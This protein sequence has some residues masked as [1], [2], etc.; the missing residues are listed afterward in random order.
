MSP[1]KS[2]LLA[3]AA[4][5]SL[6]ACATDGYAS[7]SRTSRGLKGAAIGGAA[8]AGL[9]AV[10]GGD[11]LTGAAIGAAAGAVLGVVTSDRNRYEDREGYR[12]YYERDGRAY[13]YDRD[14]R[15]RYIGY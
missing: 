1:I 7:D 10:T 8:G 11:V 14:G 15:K 5:T 6:S 2:S 3:L 13:R 9:G 12:T 4:A